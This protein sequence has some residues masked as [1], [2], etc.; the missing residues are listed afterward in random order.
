M[1]RAGAPTGRVAD[2]RLKLGQ[3]AS[4]LRETLQIGRRARRASRR[5]KGLVGVG[6]M[7][8]C[9]LTA[10]G[11]CRQSGGGWGTAGTAAATA[12]VRQA[13]GAWPVVDDGWEEGETVWSK[14]GRARRRVFCLA[15]TPPLLVS[16]PPSRMFALSF[17]SAEKKRSQPYGLWELV[18]PSLVTH[19][20]VIHGGRRHEGID[21]PNLP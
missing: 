11:P 16:R 17:C 14:E 2:E 8:G 7:A 19:I 3:R 13:D 5:D 4:Q 9:Q 18:K 20:G 12:A 21:N 15:G 1:D 6:G 10:T